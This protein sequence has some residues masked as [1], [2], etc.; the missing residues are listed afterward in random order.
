MLSQ[1]AICA[2]SLSNNCYVCVSIAT[3]RTQ[4][5]CVTSC[6]SNR[7]GESLRRKKSHNLTVVLMIQQLQQRNNKVAVAVAANV[8]TVA[9]WMLLLIA[10]V[11]TILHKAQLHSQHLSTS[12]RAKLFS[13][14]NSYSVY[15][16]IYINEALQVMQQQQQLLVCFHVSRCVVHA[17]DCCSTYACARAPIAVCP[18]YYCFLIF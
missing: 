1:A 9:V 15:V 8:T 10:V 14:R 12:S 3:N 6:K 18:L 11:V 13:Q 7:S 2:S 5:V 17:C 16:V 4:K